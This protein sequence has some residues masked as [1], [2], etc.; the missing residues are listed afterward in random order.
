MQQQPFIRAVEMLG[1]LT[2][3]AWFL[4]DIK[5]TSSV[6]SK[7][8]SPGPSPGSLVSADPWFPS[9]SADDVP[10]FWKTKEVSKKSIL[11]WDNADITTSSHFFQKYAF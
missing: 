9:E 10:L 8:L 3:C 11:Y 7:M 6:M 2:V 4:S 5:D 1:L